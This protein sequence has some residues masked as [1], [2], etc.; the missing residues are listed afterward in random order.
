MLCVV[1][2]VLCVPSFT[3]YKAVT[4]AA[5]AVILSVDATMS[6]S[7]LTE[8]RTTGERNKIN[9]IR[10][11]EMENILTEAAGQSYPF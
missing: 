1:C 8:N 2:C 7:D 9:F 6:L 5:A 11:P 4:Q 3:I 10:I